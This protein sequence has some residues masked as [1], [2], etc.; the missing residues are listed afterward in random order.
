MAPAI[1]GRDALDSHTPNKQ[2]V[3]GKPLKTI[4]ISQ[5]PTMDVKPTLLPGHCNSM[6]LNRLT[7]TP[8]ILARKTSFLTDSRVKTG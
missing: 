4:N 8:R 7:L 6:K 2:P 1:T 5:D 3:R